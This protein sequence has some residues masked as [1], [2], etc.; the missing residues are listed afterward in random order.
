MGI[1]MQ[2]IQ[3][4]A[5]EIENEIIT[6]RR[7]LHA[8]PELKMETVKTES[9]I[10]TQLE[11][12]GVD[13]IRSGIGGHGVSALIRGSL[14]GKCLGIRADCDG[15]P[16]REE[17][18]LPFASQNGNMHACGHDAHTA[19]GLGAAKLLAEN[20]HRLKGTV[21]LIFQ[22][23]EEGDRGASLMLDRKSVV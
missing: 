3:K 23:Y 20:R 13:E 12:I 19:M 16:I 15:L 18:G 22:P 5:R 2:E 8:M 21:K 1:S 17:T 14:P 4:R 10:V 11:K 9:Y 6:W 7:E